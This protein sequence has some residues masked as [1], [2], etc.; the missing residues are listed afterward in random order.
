MKNNMSN[1]TNGRSEN[2]TRM[3]TDQV[4]LST[5]VTVTKCATT[6]SHDGQ[7]VAASLVLGSIQEMLQHIPPQKQQ[8]VIELLSS[9]EFRVT[10]SLEQV[11]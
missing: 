7:T 11:N 3:R 1:D 9:T 5:H 2:L 6:T 8:Q 4:R 10:F